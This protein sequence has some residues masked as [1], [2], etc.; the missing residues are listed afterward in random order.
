M[1]S[2]MPTKKSYARIPVVFDLPDLIEVQVRILPPAEEGR[3]F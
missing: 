1:A 2:D 3:S